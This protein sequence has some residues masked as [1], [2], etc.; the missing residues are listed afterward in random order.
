MAVVA[1]AHFLPDPRDGRMTSADSVLLV[2]NDGLR[3]AR[4]AAAF[5]SAGFSVLQ[6][7]TAGIALTRCEHER[8]TV[9]LTDVF[10]PGVHGVDIARALRAC[11]SRT[12]PPLIL[13]LLDQCFDATEAAAQRLLFDGFIGEPVAPERLVRDV[14]DVRLRRRGQPWRWHPPSARLRLQH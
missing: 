8:P 12:R 10:L 13:G 4:Y 5:G 3:R 11:A 6:A 14:C 1:G 7:P 9:V 2:M